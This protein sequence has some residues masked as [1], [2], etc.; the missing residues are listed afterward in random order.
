MRVRKLIAP[1]GHVPKVER[2][3]RT[4][5]IGATIGQASR[6]TSHMMVKVPKR[7]GAQPWSRRGTYKV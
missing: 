4:P 5:G 7:V 2:V 3:P 6:L 1:T